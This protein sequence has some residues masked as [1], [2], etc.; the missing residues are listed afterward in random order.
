MKTKFTKFIFPALYITGFAGAGIIG[1]LSNSFF[2]YDAFNS[3][4]SDILYIFFISLLFIS[5]YVQELLAS[6]KVKS[7]VINSLVFLGCLTCLLLTYFLSVD[8]TLLALIYSAAML[9]LVGFNSALAVKK[10]TPP[11]K[12]VDLKQII[13]SASLIL[14]A[15]VRLFTIEFVT[16]T[17]MAWALIPAVI[18]LCTIGAGAVIVLRK[19]W[20]TI[21]NTELKRIGNM[22]C[23]FIIIFFIAYVYSFTAI[24]LVNCVFDG[25]VPAQTECIVL[26][27]QINSG[28]R[29]PTQFKVKVEIDGRIQWIPLPVTEYHKIDEENTIIVNYHYGAFNF[30]YLTYG[31][32]S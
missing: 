13:C 16:D 8:F 10:G 1:L 12:A 32:K 18:I 9:V 23:G 19:A 24:G 21:Y 5:A 25:K 26:E 7:V 15:M 4:W 2:A 20:S 27:K 31:G 14:F 30:A 17:Y 28:S 11:Q 29:T 6:R 22:I 3:L